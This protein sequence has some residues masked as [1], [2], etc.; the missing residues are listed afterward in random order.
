MVN[1]I[2]KARGAVRSAGALALLTTPA[3]GPL[4][5]V[6]AGQAWERFALRA[7]SLGIAHQPHHAPIEVARFHGDLSRAFGAPVG[8][9][10]LMLVRLGY[11][12]QP[13]ASVRRG[14]A[15]VASFRNS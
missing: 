10:P 14:V 5:W 4:A 6:N 8:E 15:M 3:T 1:A 11:A 7:T 9:Q 2:H 12:K 13:H